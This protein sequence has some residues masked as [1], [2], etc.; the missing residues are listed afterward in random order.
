MILVG[1]QQ[2]EIRRQE[3]V[4][5]QRAERK[6]LSNKLEQRQSVECAERQNR[7]RTGF[8]GFWDRLSG[9]HNQIK[10]Q[11]E[12]EAHKATI[13]DRTEKDVLITR[14]LEQRKRLNA[15]RVQERNEY[16]TQKQELK[17]DVQT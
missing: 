11:N 3:L 6:A 1:N 8:M 9:T 10:K 13:R 14:H 4:T 12:Q 17:K 16:Q 5:R 15:I 7:Y 2:F